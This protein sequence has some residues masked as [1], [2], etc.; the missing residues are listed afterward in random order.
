LND[1]ASY[2]D[3]ASSNESLDISFTGTPGGRNRRKLGPGRNRRN[4]GSVFG[5][6]LLDQHV[7]LPGGNKEL[8]ASLDEWLE[9]QVPDEATS[10]QCVDTTTE[11]D[12]MRDRLQYIISVSESLES[13]LSQVDEGIK[14]VYKLEKLLKTATQSMT[15]VT[16]IIRVF[17][18]CGG[19]IKPIAK[20]ADKVMETIEDRVKQAYEE[21]SDG[22]K[23]W[24]R[25]KDPKKTY[26][27]GFPKEIEQKLDDTR[28][29]NNGVRDK[30]EKANSAYEL[31]MLKVC[32]F[33]ST[34]AN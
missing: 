9:K 5:D 29:V 2:N 26:G 3:S 13:K 19:P 23:D 32:R 8:L 34:P 25:E 28:N 10:A 20:I 17:K 11:V 33:S 24:L 1:S 12:R 30:L 21:L 31:Y 27:A 18:C 4:R 6:K 16:K 7:N 22:T 15:T 14:K